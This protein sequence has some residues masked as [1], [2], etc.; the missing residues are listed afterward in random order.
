M[1]QDLESRLDRQLIIGGW[2][3][4]ALDN[5]NVVLVGSGPLCHFVAAALT[6]LQVGTKDSPKGALSIIDNARFNSDI[7][8][9]F[10]YLNQIP[11]DNSSKVYRLQEIL[12]V[13]NDR[14]R[15]KGIH[16]I[17]V[18]NLAEGSD[19]IVDLTNNPK[20]KY[21]SLKFAVE[22]RVPYISASTDTARGCVVSY[23]PRRGD[24]QQNEIF[25]FNEEEF[26]HREFSREIQGVVSSGVIAGL[27]VD[28][29][30]R[31]TFRLRDYET[32]LTQKVYYNI[33]S[34]ERF[35]LPHDYEIANSYKYKDKRVAVVGAGALGNFVGVNLALLGIGN[36]VFID[37]DT[38]AN[39]DRNRQL[40]YT[41][42]DNS[43]SR[44]KVVALTDILRKI[45]PEATFE[46][47]DGKIVNSSDGLSPEDRKKEVN[48]I[49]LD[50]LSQFDL[51]ISCV[52]N[53]DARLNL[54]TYVSNLRS[55]K[56]KVIP[57]IDGGTGARRIAGNVAFYIPG[58]N[59]CI[60]SQLGYSASP[61]VKVSC[62]VA[63]PSVVYTNLIIAS[64]LSGEALL[65]LNPKTSQF[66]IRSPMY[67]NSTNMYRVTFPPAQ[68]QR[69]RL[70]R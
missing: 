15:V 41:F 54:N 57:L 17:F 59:A 7:T 37:Y 2:N 12:S 61:R 22:R 24:G 67:Y 64:L 65:A 53:V 1:K 4:D 31:A 50:Y 39:T 66:A 19:V 34:R 25:A 58:E 33:L 47:V 43:I 44:K 11:L 62:G 9:E 8:N 23:D 69:C 29:I 30:R 16:S 60:D 68:F 45:N 55:N 46:G 21:R 36:V 42:D 6:G 20:S 13:M 49:S 5:A 38:V 48:P 3:Q 26:T 40:C 32:M 63:E 10:L 51:I 56:N 52:D 14:M 27:V 28:E 18:E 35:K 70:C